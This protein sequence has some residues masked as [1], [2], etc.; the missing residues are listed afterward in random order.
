MTQLQAKKKTIGGREFA[1]RM[2]DP[3][4]ASDLLIDIAETLSPGLAFGLST[5]MSEKDAAKQLIEGFAEETL[6]TGGVERM[7]FGVVQRLTKEKI[8]SFI[9]KL[10]PVTSVRMAPELMPSLDSEGTFNMVFRGH[11]LDLYV[12]L[13]FAIEVQFGDFADAFRK[14]IA[15]KLPLIRKAFSKE[16]KSPDILDDT[17]TS[18]DS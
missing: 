5:L 3:L 11:V 9:E 2:L 13:A 18:G 4:E 6:K 8:R 14:G 12:W 10:K 15:N 1:V 7:V 16:S 17:Q